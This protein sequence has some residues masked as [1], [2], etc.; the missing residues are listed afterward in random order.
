MSKKNIKAGELTLNQIIEIAD[1][2]IGSCI[3][4]PLY[5]VPH[6]HCFHF[7]EASEEELEELREELKEEV[8]VEEDD[9]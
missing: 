6:I 7:C 9:N 1:K 2:H 5:Q 8:E 3:E 4:C